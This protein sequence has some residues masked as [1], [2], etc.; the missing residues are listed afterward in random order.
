[1][2]PILLTL[3]LITITRSV[4]ACESYEECISYTRPG[5]TSNSYVL[6][7]IAYKLD[8]ISKKLDKSK[9]GGILATSDWRHTICMCGDDDNGLCKPCD[10]K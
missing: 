6:H 1:M 9:S 4:Y 10:R 2:K 7:A 5:S 3:L 8:E